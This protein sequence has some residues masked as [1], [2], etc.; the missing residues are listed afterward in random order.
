MMIGGIG[1]SARVELRYEVRSVPDAWELPEIL[2]PE[3]RPHELL[4]EH[5][6]ALLVAW[7]ERTGRDAIVARNLALRW[8]EERPKVGVDPDLCLI[9][10]APPGADHLT[11]LCTW[12]PGHTV[13]RL[14]IEVVSARHPYKD[15]AVVQDKYAV[16]GVRE[17]WVVDAFLQGPT[18]HG[19][20]VALQLWRADGGEFRCV[21]RGGGPFESPALG[22]WVRVAGESVEISD[23][24]A[25]ALRWPTTLEAE[26]TAKEQERAAKEQERAR[27]DELERRVRELEEKLAQKR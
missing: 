18:A 8:I 14:A 13:P 25:F 10:P 17:L 11:S 9:E 15:Y 23:D 4:V 26:R 22:A 1:T 5:L 6:K 12:E 2:V 3:S 16:S 21:Y 7:L 27:A 20:P 19:G 24:P